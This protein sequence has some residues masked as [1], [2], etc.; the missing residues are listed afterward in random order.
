VTTTSGVL[1]VKGHRKPLKCKHGK[2]KKTKKV[3][4]KKV[5]VCVAKT[6]AKKLSRPAH[7]RSGFTG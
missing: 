1:G 3:H 6:H 4:G 2:V 7:S 5:V